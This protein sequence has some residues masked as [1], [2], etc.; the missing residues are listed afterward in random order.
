MCVAD[1]VVKCPAGCI[2][3]YIVLI[4]VATI[5]IYGVDKL[6]AKRNL[7]RVPESA[8][9][10]L[11][12]AGGS[13]GAWTGIKVWRHKTLHKRFKYGIPLIVIV[14]ITIS[15]YFYERFFL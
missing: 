13:I 12:V 4:N 2:L 14:H 3:L 5:L 7:W 6:K 10:L 1:F 9:F 8:L 11:A 15:F